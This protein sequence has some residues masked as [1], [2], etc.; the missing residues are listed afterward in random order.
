MAQ[1]T[2]TSASGASPLT[3]GQKT[4]QGKEQMHTTHTNGTCS[5]KF[6]PHVWKYER[7]SGHYSTFGTQAA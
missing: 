1:I 7:G 3:L 5:Y 4:T 6:F 2:N